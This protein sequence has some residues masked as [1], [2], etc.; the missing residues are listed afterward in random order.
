MPKEDKND[1]KQC[2]DDVADYK[3]KCNELCN[4]LGHFY[5]FESTVNYII[6]RREEMANPPKDDAEAVKQITEALDILHEAL[7]SEFEA[8]LQ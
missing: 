2:G 8:G 6:N 4:Q 1:C 7:E 3:Q 5:V